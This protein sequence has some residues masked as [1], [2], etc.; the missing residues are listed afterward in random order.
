MIEG[1]S[2]QN[3]RAVA[4]NAFP[5]S[6]AE[7][8]LGPIANAGLGI[9]RDIGGID[10]AEI[11]EHR[12]PAGKGLTPLRRMTS[13]AITSTCQNFT[14]RHESRIEGRGGGR[15]D[16]SDGWPPGESDKSAKAENSG[17]DGPDEKTLEQEATP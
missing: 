3:M 2:G 13:G 15:R 11:G 5:D 4:R 8:F 14:A 17:G 16:R 7:G 10:G 9:R 6:A 1:K 12:S